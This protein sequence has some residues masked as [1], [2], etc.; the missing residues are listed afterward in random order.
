MSERIGIRELKSNLSAVLRR[1]KNG[2]VV[3]ITDRNDPVAVLVPTGQDRE[4]LLQQLAEA[5][6][7]TWSGG[8][9]AG[10]ARPPRVR[11]SS[12]AEA[13]EEDRR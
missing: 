5:G 13:V 9:P 7:L 10:C 4:T 2:E 12:V 1:V 11:G 8:K 6:R 3:T